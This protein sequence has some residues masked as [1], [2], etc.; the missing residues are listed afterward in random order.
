MSTTRINLYR[1]LARALGRGTLEVVTG[2]TT[3]ANGASNVTLTDVTQ[4]KYSSGDANA[5]DRVFVYQMAASDNSTRGFSRITEGGYDFANGDFT[6]SPAIATT[7]A[8]TDVYVLTHDHPYVLTEAIDVVLR[9]DYYEALYPLSMHIVQNDS[10][11][12][13]PS[14]VATDYKVSTGGAVAA[15]NTT[16]FFHGI[17]SLALTANSAN[18]YAALNTVIGVSENVD[19]YASIMCNVTSGDDAAFRIWDTTGNAEIDSATTDEPSWMNLTFQFTTPSGCEQIDARLEQIG[20]DDVAYWD[21][22]HVWYAGSGVY[23]L[24][25]FVESPSQL[26]DVV[27]YPRGTQGP[28]SDNDY[29]PNER[30]PR[31]LHWRWESQDP[32]SMRIWVGT[33]EAR[34]YLKVLRRR[35]ELSL[36][37]STTLA[38]PDWVVAMAEM[39]IREPDEASKRLREHVAAILTAPN[40]YAQ[41]RVG[42][43][44]R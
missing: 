36:D 21:D 7:V 1:D 44:I 5:Y 32:G 22:F 43:S 6:M 24:P 2:T 31:S 40:P 34:P 20:S 4:L 16:L 8:N 17:Q 12:M 23:P 10:N 28:A 11:D 14:T 29:L 41:P 9:H 37:S 18:E 25:S 30:E 3:T 35:P 38:D 15:A 13:E 27:A 19:L 33:G 26:L 39:V 42:K